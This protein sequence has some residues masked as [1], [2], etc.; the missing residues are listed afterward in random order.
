MSVQDVCS[1]YAKTLGSIPGPDEEIDSSKRPAIRVDLLEIFV[2]ILLKLIGLGP[3]EVHIIPDV[4]KSELVFI[5]T[6]LSK[7]CLDFYLIYLTI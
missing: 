6:K 2:Y 7:D 5:A 1:F 4:N 3:P